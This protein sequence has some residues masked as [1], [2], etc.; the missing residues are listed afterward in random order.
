MVVAL[1]GCGGKGAARHSGPEPPPPGDAKD[2]AQITRVLETWF[3]SSRPGRCRLVSDNFLEHQTGA[4]GPPARA[5][6]E[7]RVKHDPRGK[8]KVTLIAFSG[9][10][11]V[12]H[13]EFGGLR[14]TA[15]MVAAG[16]D[17]WLIDDLRPG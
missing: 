2:R 11:A 12:A 13:I 10:G 4:T 17:R 3:G 5:D 7:Q 16:G 6:C 14:E 1:S 15:S 9:A 8:V